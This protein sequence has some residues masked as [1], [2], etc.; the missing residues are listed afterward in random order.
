MKPT[1]FVASALCLTSPL[2]AESDSD[3]AQQLTNPLADLIS[4]PVQGNIDFGVGLGNGH[5]SVTN[6]QPVIPFELNEC[7]NLISR[8]IVPVI[9]QQGLDFVT[10]RSDAFGL[11]DVVQ[12][13]WLSPKEPEPFIWGVGGAFLL[14]TATDSAL[15]ADRWGAGPTAIVLKLNGSWTYGFLA[16]HIWDYAGGDRTGNY[17]TLPNTVLS[18]SNQVNLTYVQPFLSY[19]TSSATT[20]TLNSESTYDWVSNQWTV[21][22]N[23]QV[24]QLVTMGKVPVSLYGGVRWYAESGN[25]GPD[26]G[27]RLG[28]TVLFPKG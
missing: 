16:N 2:Y 20:L 26:W 5:R 21:P 10:D 4:M 9:D 14:P 18:T 15:G 28:F 25:Q 17:L 6:I 7:W 12:S 19:T 1:V 24:S 11:G 3:L 23:F 27:L 22:I 13:V 8:T